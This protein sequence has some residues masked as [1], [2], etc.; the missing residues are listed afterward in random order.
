MSSIR[1]VA[2]KAGVSVSSVS[3]AYHK[4]HQ[5]SVKTREK[6]LAIAELLGYHPDPNK[7]PIKLETIAIIV[8]LSGIKK[9]QIPLV[10]K[11]IEM[12]YT[13][14]Y[15]TTIV[16]Y[17]SVNDLDHKIKSL[18]SDKHSKAII[19]IY[20]EKEEIILK[21]HNL[22][23]LIISAH[24][25]SAKCINIG[26]D[27]IVDLFNGIKSYFDQGKRKVAVLIEKKYLELDYLIKL[28]EQMKVQYQL[29]LEQD[30]SDESLCC[31]NGDQG[32][33]DKLQNFQNTQNPDLW[34]IIGSYSV[35]IAQSIP[36]IKLE[37]FVFLEEHELCIIKP[38][39][40]LK[41][42]QRPLTAIAVATVDTIFELIINKKSVFHNKILIESN[43]I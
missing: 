18:E 30:F 19:I 10:A 26:C 29:I 36:N 2:K 40:Q 27:Y 33:S 15:R 41:I 7:I 11:L 37:G 32:D 35:N 12:F 42:I 22:P 43:L 31:L 16:D 13:K 17:T 6:I 4:P 24:T 14:G 21:K 39:Q 8:P 3:L 23:I 5:L 1:D 20:D 28:K 34:V 25:F 9:T 38:N